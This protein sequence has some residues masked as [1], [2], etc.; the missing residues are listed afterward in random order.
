MGN[1][2]E[3]CEHTLESLLELA[4][5]FRAR[6]N[7]THIERVDMRG[8]KRLGNLAQMDLQRQP[9]GDGRF[10][11]AWLTNIDRIIFAPAAKNLNRSLQF[12][13]TSDQRINLAGGGTFDQVHRKRL[14]R[15]TRRL[16]TISTVLLT[17]SGSE[18]LGI[19][20]DFRDAMRDVIEYIKPLDALLSQQVDSVR[21][22]DVKECF[23]DMSAVNLLALARF[24]L[25]QRIL[26][27]ALKHDCRFRYFDVLA[28]ELF[29][30]LV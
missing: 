26:Q 2:I 11:H 4:A 7:R 21:T 29:L 5:V 13:S 6:Q 23:E 1:L 8:L 25:E 3:R 17:F 14:Q 27:H 12:G 24:G 10:P 19:F 18:G 9:F 28:L 30:V 16:R 20:R 15:I 22:L